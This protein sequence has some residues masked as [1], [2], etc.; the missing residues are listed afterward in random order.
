MHTI[1][2]YRGNSHRQ[3][4]TQTGAITIHCTPALLVRSVSIHPNVL[5]CKFHHK[6]SW[7][8]TQAFLISHLHQH[9]QIFTALVMTHISNSALYLCKSPFD[10]STLFR[11]QCRGVWCQTY[12]YLP[13][14]L[15]ACCNHYLLS[16]A[17]DLLAMFTYPMSDI[18]Y[19]MS[20]TV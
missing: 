11:I 8:K 6:I 7:N 1:S 18:V 12:C 15:H 4:N 10:K 20:D 14:I 5:V 19:P 3:T 2:S 16:T 9:Y 17:F 13:S